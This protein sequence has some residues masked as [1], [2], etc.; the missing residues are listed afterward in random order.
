MVATPSVRV[1]VITCNGKHYLEK[2][3]PSLV[4]TQ[5]PNYSIWL[6]DNDSNDGSS[7]YVAEMHKTVHVVRNRRNLG[8]AKGN[9]RVMLDAVKAGEDY[10]LLLNDDT[11]ILD[12]FWISKAITIVD[13]DP[14]I[15]MLGFDLTDDL[16][17][18][19]PCGLGFV[20]VENIVGCALLIRCRVLEDIGFFDEAY[21]AYCEESD[22]E[23]RAKRR[24]YHLVRVNVPVYHAGGGSFG[25]VPVK[26]AYLYLRNNIRYSV[27]N[28]NL[29]RV[30]VR[31]FALF[32]YACSPF[33]FQRHPFKITMRNRILANGYMLVWCL[34]GI[35]IVWNVFHAPFTVWRRVM[36]ALSVRRSR[37]NKRHWV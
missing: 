1:I 9:N 18:R 21:F 33:P 28:E 25:K 11:V 3:L 12:P 8:F 2:C 27:K 26:F 24:G 6:I 31:P 36:E 30:C 14:S 4:G 15:G 34:F 29:F 17:K 7:V 35:A 23:C 16:S 20:E 32:D 19:S 37:A 13:A 5:Y 22:L 10:V